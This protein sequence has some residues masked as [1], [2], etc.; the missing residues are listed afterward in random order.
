MGLSWDD[1]ARDERT[2]LD[3]I[4]S[5]PEFEKKTDEELVQ[6][7]KTTTYPE[8]VRLFMDDLG[9]GLDSDLIFPISFSGYPPGTI[10][11]P[12]GLPMNLS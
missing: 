10:L 9:E 2:N 12:D 4:D 7:L 1:I 5:L 3:M 6:Y 8:D 11:G